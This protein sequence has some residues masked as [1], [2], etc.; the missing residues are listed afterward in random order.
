MQLAEQFQRTLHTGRDFPQRQS[1]VSKTKQRL[2]ILDEENSDEKGA[3][4]NEHAVKLAIVQPRILQK[5]ISEVR[6]RMRKAGVHATPIYRL[7]AHQNSAS[8]GLLTSFRR[9]QPGPK[10]SECF[11]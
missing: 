6:V 4:Q 7:M 9:S 8:C 11:E 2:V 5:C 10:Q 1:S 3:R